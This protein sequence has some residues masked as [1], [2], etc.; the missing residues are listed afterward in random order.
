MR[1]SRLPSPP[2]LLAFCDINSTDNK[3]SSKDDDDEV[4]RIAS[5]GRSRRDRRRPSRRRREFS[6]GFIG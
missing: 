6:G 3:V 2:P 5:A 4:K 1:R